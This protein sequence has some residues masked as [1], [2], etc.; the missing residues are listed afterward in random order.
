MMQDVIV[1]LIFGLM[2]IQTFFVHINCSIKLY[3]CASA[4]YLNQ[5]NC[6]AFD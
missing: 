2:A 5:L 3:S 4:S 6:C 1:H